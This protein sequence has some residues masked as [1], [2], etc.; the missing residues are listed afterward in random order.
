MTAGQ[1]E[2]SALEAL[3]DRWVDA[4]AGRAGDAFAACCTADVAYEDPV[5]TE[6]L[7]GLA[8]LSAH[9][10]RLRGAF[11]DLSVECSA[12][13]LGD[14]TF[15]CLPWRAA[16]TNRGALGPLPATRR[17]VVVHGLHY[18]ELSDGRVRRARGFF[19]LYGAAV[20]L[21][22]LPGRGTRGESA[23]L[24]LRGFGLR[25]AR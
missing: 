22:L 25:V 10:E 6:P 3:G 18:V 5:A 2:R 12:R 15:A 16:G 8:A 13:P 1:A 17:H 4:W 19:D 11:P 9:A 20:Q 14:A 7:T 24:A 23:L 21:G